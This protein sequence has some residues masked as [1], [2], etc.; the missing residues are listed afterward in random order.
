MGHFTVLGADPTET[1]NTAMAARA[2]IGMG[3][4]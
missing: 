2:A 4:D 1:V 3:N